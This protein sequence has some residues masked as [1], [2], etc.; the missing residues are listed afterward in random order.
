M[1]KRTFFVIGLAVLLVIAVVLLGNRGGNVRSVQ[2]IVGESTIYT[3]AEIEDA[4]DVVEQKF[5]KDF[6]DCKLLRLEYNEGKTLTERFYRAEQ[7]GVERVIVLE[8]DY[9][10]GNHAEACFTPDYTYQNWKWILTD[11][12]DG[13]LLRTSGY[14]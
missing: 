13:W 14:G 2:R 1:K 11:E 10:V 9:Y 5:K 4:M 6:Y 7:Y 3:D 12:G 8:S